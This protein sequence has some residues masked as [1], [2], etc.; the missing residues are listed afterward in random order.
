MAFGIINDIG[1]INN[2]YYAG[3]Y[4]D[5]SKMWKYIIK[6]ISDKSN[7]EEHRFILNED[8]RNSGFTI[9]DLE[10]EKSWEDF[11]QQAIDIDFE[12]EKLESIEKIWNQSLKDLLDN[13]QKFIDEGGDRTIGTTEEASF[14]LK[15]IKNGDAAAS[16]GLSTPF[17]KPWYN[18]DG[19]DYSF[20][21]AFDL[22]K[23][24]VENKLNLQFTHKAAT[25]TWLRLIMPKYTRRVEVEDLNRNFWAIAQV[26]S[27]ISDY[28]FNTESG[29]ILSIFGDILDE[30]MQL[31]E[32]IL[33]LWILYAI[34]KMQECNNIH[35]E[36]VPIQNW[37]GK[38][39]RMYDLNGEEF[40]GGL[41]D[42]FSNVILSELKNEDG[43]DRDNINKG[44]CS[45]AF[46][47]FLQIYTENEADYLYR[48][49]K[50]VTAGSVIN[51]D[52]R[53]SNDV[54][55][56]Y[57][58]KYGNS[59]ICV[60]PYYRFFNYYRNQFS[61][62]AIPCILL[63]NR[64]K[65]EWEIIP[66]RDKN[67]STEQY[68]C[69]A[70]INLQDFYNGSTIADYLQKNT[71][72]IKED[73][74]TNSY[75]YFF[76]FAQFEQKG[77]VGD[78]Y[79]VVRFEPDFKFEH[80]TREIFLNNCCFN[81]FDAGAIAL[82]EDK[83]SRKVG[84]YRLE[85]DNSFIPI[86]SELS[87]GSKIYVKRGFKC[88]FETQGEMKP[89][90][91][92]DQQ[93]VYNNNKAIDSNAFYL[94]EVLSVRK[95]GN[96]LLQNLDFRIIKIGDFYPINIF[97]KN[98]NGELSKDENDKLFKDEKIENVVLS[99]IYTN[100]K[101]NMFS[102]VYE[103][104]NNYSNNK[105]GQMTYG[106]GS[107]YFKARS[108]N[109][110]FVY[111]N[112]NFLYSEYFTENLTEV[113]K[114]KTVKDIYGK[115]DISDNKYLY[116]PFFYA[117]EL[118]PELMD[119]LSIE[120][121]NNM[122]NKNDRK[123]ILPAENSSNSEKQ[124]VTLFNDNN[125]GVYAA[126]IGIN[127]WSGDNGSQWSY[128]L[129]HNLLYYSGSQSYNLGRIQLFDGYWTGNKSGPYFYS[130]GKSRWRRLSLTGENLQGSILANSNTLQNIRA[131][132]CVL[133]WF[134]HNLEVKDN[135]EKAK[136]QYKSDK[137]NVEKAAEIKNRPRCN[138]EFSYTNDGLKVDF[139]DS[140]MWW[141]IQQ[142]NQPQF[143][144]KV[145]YSDSIFA[146]I[147]KSASTQGNNP[148]IL[149][150]KKD[151][152]TYEIVLHGGSERGRSDGILLKS[153]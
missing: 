95:K 61:A 66:L 148:A 67:L 133:R 102:T 136:E 29:G 86:E 72:G 3:D 134:D 74:D 85:E 48:L 9:K 131:E 62:I 57:K 32:N 103:D 91:G 139:I 78:Y 19:K 6:Y 81:L 88:S 59:N 123:S 18:I 35:V 128:G 119:R 132:N 2:V 33:Y 125:P 118:K 89:P 31:W 79:S 37:G 138:F 135:Y 150:D 65:N 151:G 113:E 49:A 122:K 1:R 28:L 10:T 90:R 121:L 115:L 14:G 53:N 129:V 15:D 127:Y 26:I 70:I 41:F 21:R 98:N 141:P 120:Y 143:V 110:K 153:K 84:V 76:P 44:T 109:N 146:D 96:V 56:H 12:Q 25:D 30:I 27:Y 64:F 114:K 100:I 39:E 5:Y 43:S 92:I 97:D 116:K 106:I 47:T 107:Y 46:T 16:F 71:V 145:I 77:G 42:R 54:Y 126:K 63:Y 68:N 34:D 87:K 7:T 142:E 24:V 99:N 50:P 94:G 13:F 101:D 23:S 22:V 152:K 144:V 52:E 80:N 36:M 38:T 11:I 117:D 4:F 112:Y 40:F 82:G 93:N 60:I 140:T 147:G 69:P 55:Y 130:V 73:L 111:F 20:V 58:F 108:R 137:D 45:Q 17:V 124:L 104:N 83:N 75:S 105:M 149:F 8:Y 51:D